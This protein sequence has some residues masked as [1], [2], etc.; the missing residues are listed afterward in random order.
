MGMLSKLSKKKS[1]LGLLLKGLFLKWLCKMDISKYNKTIY[2]IPTN[3]KLDY[4]DSDSG[5]QEE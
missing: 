3:I 2:I 4:K 5:I 1:I